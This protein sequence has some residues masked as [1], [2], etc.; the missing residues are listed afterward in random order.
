[1]ERG[2]E[3]FVEKLRKLGANISKEKDDEA[4]PEDSKFCDVG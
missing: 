4:E 3:N 1:M 2:Y